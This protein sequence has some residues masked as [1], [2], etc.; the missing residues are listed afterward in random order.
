[1]SIS[2]SRLV[3]RFFLHKYCTNDIRF[4]IDF[5]RLEKP[6]TDGSIMLHNNE[7]VH[8][9]SGLVGG[10]FVDI[11][12]RDDGLDDTFAV[13]AFASASG[14]EGGNG[15]VELEPT[16]NQTSRQLSPNAP[17]AYL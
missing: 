13:F 10:S 6:G 7:N 1:M 12:A 4:I 2:V 15:V 14:L 9:F 8:S 5:K 16:N 3:S 17:G 11:G